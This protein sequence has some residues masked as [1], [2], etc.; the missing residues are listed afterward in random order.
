MKHPT[1][2]DIKSAVILPYHG[3]SI[4]PMETKGT[5]FE[6]SMDR[7]VEEFI[8]YFT[9]LDDSLNDVKPGC[10]WFVPSHYN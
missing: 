8:E 7:H 4:T 6:K 3:F 5:I 9:R 1:P 2:G 10:V